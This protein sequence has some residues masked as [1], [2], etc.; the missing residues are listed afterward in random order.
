M[1]LTITEKTAKELY[2]ETPNWFQKILKETF[3]KKCF[4]K[5]KFDEIKTFDDACR[6]CSMTELDFNENFGNKGLSIDTIAYEKLKIIIRAINQN[7]QPNWNDENQKKW[8]PYFNLSS[9]FGFSG[10]VYDYDFTGASVG[11]RLCFESKEKAD[12][13]A[14]QFLKIYEDFLT[15]K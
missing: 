2:P 8:W 14:N 15:I 7:W 6:E 10:S 1:E 3:G 12:Y 9:G 11:S 4:E 13:A 5:R